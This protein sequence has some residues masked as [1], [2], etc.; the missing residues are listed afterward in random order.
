M[1][2]TVQNGSN[3]ALSREIVERVL[4][5]IPTAW[6]HR[7]DDVLIGAKT[8]PDPKVIFHEKGRSVSV[9]GPLGKDVAACL[10]EMLTALSIISERGDLPLRIGSSLRAEHA[11]SAK[12][13]LTKA[14]W[15]P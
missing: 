13:V 1:K 7:V 6:K 11:Q 10:E 4:A 12:A 3:H 9:Y 2:V 15:Q 5:D 8:T 14:G